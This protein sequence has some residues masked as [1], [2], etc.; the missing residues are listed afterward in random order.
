MCL[1]NL[2]LSLI[3]T[4]I[5][6]SFILTQSLSSDT[7]MISASSVTYVIVHYNRT[8]S[9]HSTKTRPS[10]LTATQQTTK[11][12]AVRV[13]VVSILDVLVSNTTATTGTKNVSSAK[14][15]SRKSA[16]VDSSP[17]ITIS[18]AH[19]VSRTHSPRDVQDVV[20]LC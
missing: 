6:Q 10:A 17:K 9:L 8:A 15:A 1:D 3:V 13:V 7:G 2:I 11:R 20:S 18:T 14:S 12:P 4:L 19:R 16:R 5:P